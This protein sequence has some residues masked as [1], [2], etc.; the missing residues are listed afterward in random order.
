M[1]RRWSAVLT[2]VAGTVLSATVLAQQ[3]AVKAVPKDEARERNLR[4]YTELLRSD[5]RTQKVALITELMQFTDSQDEKFWPVYREYE[6]E[7]RRLNDDRLKNLQSYAD[8]Y[9]TLNDA[10]AD[11]L[12]VKALDLEARRTALRQ[13]YYAA[14]KKALPAR[15]AARAVQIEHQVDLLIDLQVA[16]ALPIVE[17]K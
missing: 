6:N 16:A 15:V 14:L 3:N 11:S 12:V 4:A 1:K 8:S 10:Q 9:T 2:I 13:K 17:P 7:V 5:L